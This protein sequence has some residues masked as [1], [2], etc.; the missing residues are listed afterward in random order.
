MPCCAVCNSLSTTGSMFADNNELRRVNIESFTTS[1]SA[2]PFFFVSNE[3]HY[4]EFS[5]FIEIA[6]HSHALI[7]SIPL[8]QMVRL[9]AAMRSSCSSPD[10]KRPHHLFCVNW[11]KWRLLRGVGLCGAAGVLAVRLTD[12]GRPQS[13]ALLN[14]PLQAIVLRCL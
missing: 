9:D 6:D 3:V 11:K 12:D 1:R 2:P 5:N 13:S 7:G 10:N 8:I 14:S 4:A